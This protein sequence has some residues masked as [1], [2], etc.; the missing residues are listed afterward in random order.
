MFWI[1]YFILGI[2]Y[3][4]YKWDEDDY[5][6]V[7]LEFIIHVLFYPAFILMDIGR[8]LRRIV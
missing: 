1:I 2:V 8:W 6:G 7:E 4:G 3:F 5:L